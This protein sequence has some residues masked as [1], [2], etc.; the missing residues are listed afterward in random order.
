MKQFVLLLIAM[1]TSNWSAA[2]EWDFTGFAGVDSRA[3]WLDS[4]YPEQD[5]SLNISLMLQPEVYWRSADNRQRLSVVGFARADSHDSNRSHADLREAYWGYEGRNW[6]LNVGVNKVFWGVTESRHLVDIINQTDLIEDID[7]EDKLGQPMVNLNL[8]RDIGRFGLYVMPWFRTRT[9]PGENGRLRAMLPVDSDNAIYESSDAKRHVDLALRYSHFIGDIDI[10]V[11]VFDG[12]SREPRFSIAPG[13]NRLLPVYDQMT[14]FGIDVQYTRD[15]WLWKLEAIARDTRSDSFAAAVGG[16][17]YTFYGV[18]GSAADVG[19]LLE[20]LYDGRN[21]NAPP[22]AFE[23]DVFAGMRFALN[24]ADDTSLLAG[25]AV[26]IR[27]HELFFNVEAERR[28]G[29]SLSMGLR[30]RSFMNA[31]PGNPLYAFDRDDY[32]QL[33]LSRYF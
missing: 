24:D 28:F 10:G 25:F 14:Q 19:V 4:R 17:E 31:G 5:D 21:A 9:F 3:F 12:T 33:R 8:Q 20:Y 22:T 30:L 29:D 32:L 6:D 13:G 7:Q 18:G 23:N 11:H 2:S 27:T 1:L 26:D 15:Q 16:V